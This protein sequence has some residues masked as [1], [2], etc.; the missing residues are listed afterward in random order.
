[1]CKV[2]VGLFLKFGLGVTGPKRRFLGIFPELLAFDIANP[3]DNAPLTA[4]S[5]HLLA[6]GS[7]S[8]IAHGRH[9]AMA[10]VE[11]TF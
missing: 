7:L 1:V 11:G 6:S 5:L 9:G 10:V 8:K 2:Y 4:R 3:P